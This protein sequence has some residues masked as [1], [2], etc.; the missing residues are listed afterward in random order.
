MT[1]APLSTTRTPRICSA[2]EA[3]A[4]IADGATIGVSGSG[5]G[6][7]EADAI[8]AAIERRFL[9]TGHPHGITVVHG[10]GIGDRST[11]G[12]NRLRHPGL[13]A[14]VIGAHWTWAPGLVELAMNNEIE[15]YSFPAGVINQ[16]MRET[17][18][19]R[20]GLTTRV[21]LG[22]YV[23]PRQAGGRM[24]DKA[25]EEFVTLVKIDGTE[26][27]HYQPIP[28]DAAIIRGSQ[29]D[30]RGGI[31]QCHEAAYLDSF[32]LALAAQGSGGMTLAQV[33]EAAPERLR[34]QQVQIPAP[35]VDRVVI[36]PEQQ[37]TYAGEY[38][39]S[40]AGGPYDATIKPDL[41]AD[42]ARQIIARRAAMEVEEDVILNLGFGISAHVTDVLAIDG[43]LDTVT[44][45]IEQGHYGGVL[46]S[47]DYFGMSHQSEALISSTDQFDVFASGRIDIS[48][49]GMAQADR[50]G[51]VNVSRVGG[52]IMGPGGFIDISANAARIVYCG[53][54]TA[55]GLRVSRRDGKLVIDN[56]GQIPKFVEE[57]E[58]ITY[59]GPTAYADGRTALYV[60]ERA[61][62][63]LGP[64]GLVLTEIA[65]GIDLQRD[66]LDQMGFQPV[67]GDLKEMPASLFAEDTTN[68]GEA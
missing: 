16:L 7:L 13:L 8:L 31:S 56:E 19:R 37:Q 52:R 62:F 11:T 42:P 57:V 55:K 26:Y 53:T 54:F 61:V 65:P 14:R 9:E 36:E 12:L 45:I 49:L 23:D 29:L 2:D 3:V 10:F 48:A 18:A 20:P 24:N 1:G 28:L 66:V 39:D 68:E 32:A 38:L 35:L 67:I 64:D 41:P 44:T 17:G 27:L 25:T 40:L 46:A 60:T 5:G 22:T 51:N 34:P 43:R 33:K 47:G 58:E 50:A 4:D 63:E 6:I 59:S 21:G 15:A 30:Q